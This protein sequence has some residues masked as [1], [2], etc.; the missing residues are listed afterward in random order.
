MLNAAWFGVPQ[1]RE[2]FILIGVK[3]KY[4]KLTREEIKLPEPIIDTPNDFITVEEAIG[5]LEKI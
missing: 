5:D 2:R 1:T 4:R 3:R